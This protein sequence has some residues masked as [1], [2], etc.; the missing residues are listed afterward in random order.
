MTQETTLSILRTG[1]NVFLTGEPGSGKTHT[2]NRYI[3][4]LRERGIEPAVTASTGIAATHIGGMTIHS[5]SGIGVRKGLTP[6]DLEMIATNKRVVKRIQRTA[7]LIIDEVSMLSA[8]TLAMAEQV[9][10]RVRQN[11]VPFGGLQVVLAGDFFQLPPVVARAEDSVVRLGFGENELGEAPAPFAFRSRAWEQLSPVVCYLSEQH[12]QEDAVFLNLLAL[13]RSGAA[14]QRV[15]TILATR[16]TTELQ[17]P[18]D[19]PRLFSHNADVDRV[20]EKRLASISGRARRHQMTA[21]GPAGLGATLKRGCLS[22][23]V[24]S[25]KVGARV[26]FTKNNPDGSFVNG[27]LGEVTGFGDDGAPIVETIRGRQI[28]AEPM[29]WTITDGARIL[30][31]IEQVPLRL[32]WAITVHKSQ[33]MTLDAAVMDLSAAFEYGQGYVALSRVRALSGLHILGWNDRALEIHPDTLIKDDE[34]RSQS[35]EAREIFEAKSQ[36]DL[37]IMQV[38]F[39]RACGGH[40]QGGVSTRAGKDKKTHSSTISATLALFKSGQTI[41]EIARARS[42]AESTVYSHISQLYAKEQISRAELALLVP[43]ALKRALP[44][45]HAAFRELGVERLTPVFEK[46]EGAYSYRDLR[47]ARMLME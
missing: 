39:I 7:V 32:A 31:H 13:V 25:L 3:G 47:F 41:R 12:R 4:W 1:A 24:L 11:S 2:V 15:E 33:G 40:F 21:A 29:E 19:L 28:Y 46:F 23:E 6:R 18:A 16:R 44:L 37:E 35:A 26:M 9:C 8:T 20:N 14:D 10:R 38:N 34:F 36:K 45:I 17:A 42:L 5:W 43:P 22:P 30:A 27:T